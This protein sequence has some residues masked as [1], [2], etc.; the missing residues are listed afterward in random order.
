MAN[1]TDYREIMV[2]FDYEHW[3]L[4]PK[5]LLPKLYP[6]AAA[7]VEDLSFGLNSI[8]QLCNVQKGHQC[9]QSEFRFIT[10]YDA[11]M[12]ACT[13]DQYPAHAASVR[14]PQDQAPPNSPKLTA[15]DHTATKE[16]CGT[17]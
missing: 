17:Y 3:A 1:Y 12:S 14:T 4:Y 7:R 15:Q 6:Q 10:E 2:D 13:C 9:P 8:S 16:P 5:A 11:E